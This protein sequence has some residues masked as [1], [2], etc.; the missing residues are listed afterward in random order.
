MGDSDDS[1][2]SFVNLNRSSALRAVIRQKAG[3]QEKSIGLP[4][5]T[6]AVIALIA[7]ALVLFYQ[8]NTNGHKPQTQSPDRVNED[9]H[10]E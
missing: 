9:R 1:N 3:S 7:I 6:L 8:F 10:S 4:R 2:F 5:I